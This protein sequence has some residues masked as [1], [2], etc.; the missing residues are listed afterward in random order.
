M[1]PEI[2]F[3]LYRPHEGK[4]A[5]LRELIKKHI[6]TLRRLELVTDRAPILVKSKNGTY[7]EI[8]EWKSAESADQ[9][10]QHPVDLL[11]LNLPR[12]KRRKGPQCFLRF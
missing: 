1:K 11:G 12:F 4:D 2:V 6:P 8:F 9:A 5:E 3:A 7:I 10:H